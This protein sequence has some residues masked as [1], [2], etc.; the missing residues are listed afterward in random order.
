[1]RERANLSSENK[2]SAN[3]DYFCNRGVGNVDRYWRVDRVKPP[4]KNC[5]S[6]ASKEIHDALIEA[7]AS[8]EEATRAAEV[9]TTNNELKTDRAVVRAELTMVK[10]IVSGVGFGVLLLIIERFIG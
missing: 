10:W 5:M 7:G 2:Y 4:N 6:V 1:M 3:L 9:V 8:E